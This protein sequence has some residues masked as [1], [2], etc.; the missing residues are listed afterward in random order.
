MTLCSRQQP[1]LPQKV[2]NK[3]TTRNLFTLTTESGDGTY[4]VGDHHK[5]CPSQILLGSLAE[6]LL[7]IHLAEAAGHDVSRQSEPVVVASVNIF[8]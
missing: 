1:V 7:D 4:I 2:S 5:S 3:D 6:P 8:D